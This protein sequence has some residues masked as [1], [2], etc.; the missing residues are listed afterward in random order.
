MKKNSNKNKHKREWP[1]S[2]ACFV[3]FVFSKSGQIR[4][5]GEEWRLKHNDFSFLRSGHV[6]S[7]VFPSCFSLALCNTRPHYSVLAACTTSTNKL[8][9]KQSFS[10][11]NT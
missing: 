8:N 6:R 5:V 3:Y 7:E 9:K 4:R 2:G 1:K 11:Q 10:N